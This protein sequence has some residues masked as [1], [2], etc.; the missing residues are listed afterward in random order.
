MGLALPLPLPGLYYIPRPW[1]SLWAYSLTEQFAERIWLW[2]SGKY[3][4]N[5]LGPSRKKKW[6]QLWAREVTAQVGSHP[7]CALGVLSAK[8]W[9]P[10]VWPGSPTWENCLSFHVYI[11]D[12]QAHRWWEGHLPTT[13]SG[14]PGVR[15]ENCRV[16]GY[17]SCIYEM[18]FLLFFSYWGLRD[19]LLEKMALWN[20]CLRKPPIWL[21]SHLGI[22][23]FRLGESDWVRV[24]T[25]HGV[26]QCPAAKAFAAV[27]SQG[28]SLQ[29]S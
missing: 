10:R 29:D 17:P 18:C 19:I 13:V 21:H 23:K 24:V 1:A 7:L 20:Y 2:I 14:F 11:K 25:R 15:K 5:N 8:Q 27:K 16:S 22:L 26:T 4:N 6:A 9:T 12:A 3:V 28:C